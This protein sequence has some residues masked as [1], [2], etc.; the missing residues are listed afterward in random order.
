MVLYLHSCAF[1]EDFLEVETSEL[2]STG[3]HWQD[4]SMTACSRHIQSKVQQ[5]VVI[6]ITIHSG[7]LSVSPCKLVSLWVTTYPGSRRV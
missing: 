5:A 7:P 1:R 2:H 3:S 4:F 6:R